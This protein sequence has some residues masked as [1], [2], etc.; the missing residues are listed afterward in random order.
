MI[1]YSEAVWARGGDGEAASVRVPVCGGEWLGG[2]A[3][4][5]R[6]EARGEEEEEV[7]DGGRRYSF[8]NETR[9]SATLEKCLAFNAPLCSYCCGGG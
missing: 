4:G 1:I 8:T 3:R 6:R 7:E 9:G 5:E 2:V